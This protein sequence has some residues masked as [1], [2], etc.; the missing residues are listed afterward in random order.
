MAINEASFTIR[1]RDQTRLDFES[2]KEVRMIIMIIS[3]VM[4]NVMMMAIVMVT[5]MVMVIVVVKVNFTVVAREVAAGGR[6]SR[7]SVVV[8]V[9]DL[10]DNP[11]IFLEVI[12]LRS[13]SIV[14]E[15]NI[16]YITFTESFSVTIRGLHQRRHPTR[17]N[18]CMG[19][20]A[21]DGDDDVGADDG[22]DSGGD[23]DQT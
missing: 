15:W 16:K 10:N 7:A 4:V 19:A 13:M 18:C 5:V 8:H 23:D 1:V 9:R 12:F 20:G 21:D 2:L 22:D 3:M 17:R 14:M 11:P 6:E